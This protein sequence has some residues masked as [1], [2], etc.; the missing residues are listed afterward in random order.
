[1]I[2]ALPIA[3][4]ISMDDL[5]VGEKVSYDG[6]SALIKT[7]FDDTKDAQT[8]TELSTA[9]TIEGIVE[10]ITIE[11]LASKFAKNETLSYFEGKTIISINGERISSFKTLEDF[12]K[13][14]AN[15]DINEM[16][17]VDSNNVITTL[18]QR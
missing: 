15:G 6:L 18:I 9:I 8:E 11:K 4:D 7:I 2:D 3:A 1:M 14:F 16:E 5:K 13:Y 17:I 10:G 12:F